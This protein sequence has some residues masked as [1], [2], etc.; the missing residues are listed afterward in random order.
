MEL[1]L[2]IIEFFLERDDRKLMIF[3]GFVTVGRE[4]MEDRLGVSMDLDSLWVRAAEVALAKVAMEGLG[5][6]RGM[7]G[8]SSSLL[9]GLGRRNLRWAPWRFAR[10]CIVLY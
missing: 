6:A 10:L 1:R 8:L 7:G 4:G 9:V 5:R 2:G 3:I